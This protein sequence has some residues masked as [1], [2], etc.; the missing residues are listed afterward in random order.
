MP[1]IIHL[2]AVEIKPKI[3]DRWA[4]SLV[5]DEYANFRVM[6]IKSSINV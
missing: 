1:P 4:G 2:F 5:T 3:F 6:P